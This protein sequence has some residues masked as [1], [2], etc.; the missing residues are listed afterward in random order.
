MF[1]LSIDGRG[2]SELVSKSEMG[3]IYGAIWTMAASETVKWSALARARV[4][5]RVDYFRRQEEEN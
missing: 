4:L 1:I 2:G 3:Y 5:L